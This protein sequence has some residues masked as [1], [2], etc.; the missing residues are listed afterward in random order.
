[1]TLSTADKV[2]ALRKAE[3]FGAMSEA[4]LN[5]VV[6]MAQEVTYQ[7]GEMF[8]RQGERGDCLYLIVDGEA[9]V[10]L[11]GAGEVGR[12]G[13]NSVIG[14]LAILWKQPRGASCIAA[15][16][17]TLLRVSYVDFWQL[18]ETHPRLVRSAIDV[19]MRR[20]TEHTDNLKKY[21]VDT[22]E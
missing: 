9:R 13:A 1:M 2:A 17:L 14:E 21:G 3:L 4:D 7:A 20:L 11:D 8:I 6:E 10:T 12:R 16:P 18:M 22:M 15:S 5:S 19:L